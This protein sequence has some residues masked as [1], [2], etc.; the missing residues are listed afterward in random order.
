M[1]TLYT[2]RP[3]DGV[4][5]QR[6]QGWKELGSFSG[7]RTPRL[8]AGMV[9][10]WFKFQGLWWCAALSAKTAM[11]GKFEAD[12]I[13]VVSELDTESVA[14]VWS[15]TLNFGGQTVWLS[16]NEMAMKLY[17][18]DGSVLSSRPVDLPYQEPVAGE[19]L[20]IA[21]L[22]GSLVLLPSTLYSQSTFQELRLRVR[23]TVYRLDVAAANI[24]V[25]ALTPDVDTLNVEIPSSE[26]QAGKQIQR[27]VIGAGVYQDKLF[28]LRA[29]GKLYE[30][31][32]NTCLFDA[33]EHKAMACGRTATSVPGSE[34]FQITLE[35]STI[36]AA[37]SSLLGA[38]VIIGSGDFAG[39]TGTVVYLKGQGTK[40]LRVTS[41]TA[42]P[43]PI[44]PANTEITFY[45]GLAGGHD[46]N[47]CP[48]QPGAWVQTAF[49]EIAQS[50]Y[51]FVL[52][53]SGL[54]SV[55]PS[56][57]SQPSYVLRLKDGKVE[58]VMLELNGR[59][60]NALSLQ[61]VRDSTDGSLH[62]FYFDPA[63]SKVRHVQCNLTTLT[64]VEHESIYSSDEPVHVTNSPILTFDSGELDVVLGEISADVDAGTVSVAYSV[65]S[66]DAD[67]H[68]DFFYCIGSSWKKAT[69]AAEQPIGSFIHLLRI[70]EPTFSGDIQYK[71]S[72]RRS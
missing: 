38:R 55:E 69:G 5:L 41:E 42:E 2:L 34:D 10:T 59:P 46:S 51:V 28:E 64:L 65:F 8:G 14:T 1:K 20:I 33:R 61:T 32:S 67:Y 22:G 63:R 47:S 71:V 45:R 58:Q 56:R 11:I 6:T 18:F 23:S 62:L 40:Y 24:V 36:P 30:S 27:A 3:S 31:G 39:Q 7:L 52:G 16:M 57:S 13:T 53:R 43:F 70:D 26:Q 12:N 44:L 66:S 37:L 17:S 60:L 9:S 19:S 68:L 49:H 35:E 29:S 72:V 50:L 21:I 4:I 54:L 15:N 48:M 25:T